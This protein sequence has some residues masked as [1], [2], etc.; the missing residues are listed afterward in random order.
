MN[1]VIIISD[2]MMGLLACVSGIQILCCLF[3]F[4]LW[5]IP[6]PG[7]NGNPCHDLS[8]DPEAFVNHGD[9]T[10]QQLSH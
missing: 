7:E 8:K 2:K 10:P 9:L 1:I 3:S 6:Q 5:S 4:Y